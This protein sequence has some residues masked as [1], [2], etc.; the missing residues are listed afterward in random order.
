MVFGSEWTA[1]MPINW[2]RWGGLGLRAHMF[3]AMDDEAV[4]VCQKFHLICAPTGIPENGPMGPIWDQM[5]IPT[6][7][8]DRGFVA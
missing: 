1:L 5:G 2:A 8:I 6:E 3:V 4:S 7:S